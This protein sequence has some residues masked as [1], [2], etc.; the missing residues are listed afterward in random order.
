VGGQVQVQKQVS[1]PIRWRCVYRLFCIFCIPCLG[2]ICTWLSKWRAHKCIN[3]NQIQFYY[4]LKC[5]STI[6][7]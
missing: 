2:S 5:E 4:F 1:Y 7:I 6:K 3:E